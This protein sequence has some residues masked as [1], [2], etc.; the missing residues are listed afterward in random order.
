MFLIAL[1]PVLRSQILNLKSS[2]EVTMYLLSRHI[3]ESVETDQSSL[4][5]PKWYWIIAWRSWSFSINFP[6]NKYKFLILSSTCFSSLSLYKMQTA[7]TNIVEAVIS[8][9]NAYQG[10][11]NVL[12][13]L[14]VIT[15]LL[16]CMMFQDK[17]YS[18]YISR[19]IVP[20]SFH[21]KLG[22]YTCS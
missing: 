21:Y 4:P 20:I 11:Q 5:E 18:A 12:F 1:L 2:W 19:L 10:P 22:I 7:N 13:F 9:A 6:V 8:Q 17:N 3:I 14:A 16:T 15:L